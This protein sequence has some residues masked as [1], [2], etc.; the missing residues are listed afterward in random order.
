MRTDRTSSGIASLRAAL[1]L[2]SALA[3]PGIALAQ[4]TAPAVSAK[5]VA[6]M[7]N[8]SGQIDEIVVTAQKRSESLQD[9]PISIQALGTKKLDELQVNNF[10]D[11][12]KY[13]PSVSFQ[14]VGPGFAQVFFRGVSSGENGNHSGPLPTVGIYLDEQPITTI[15]GALDIHVYDIA[16]V[17]ALAGPQGTLYGASSEA[18]TIRI[19]TNKP[20]PTKFSAS[21]DL[22]GTKVDGGGFGGK[23]EGYV[24]VPLSDHVAVRAVGWYQHDG[25]YI[26]NVRGTR[27]YPIKKYDEDGNLVDLPGDDITIDN[28][29]RAK[30]NYNDVDTY[31]GRAQLGIDLDDSW[32]ITP[33]IMA[34]EQKSRG[35]FAFDP[36]VGDLKVTHFFPEGAKD[37]WFQAALTITGKIADFDITYAGA[38]L[39][40]AVDSQSDYTDYS[41][42]YDQCCGYATY[43]RDN[44]GNQIAP[45]QHING[46]DRFT[47][48]SQEF[49]IASPSDKRFRVI[50]GAFYQRQSHN[51]EQ[52]YVIDNLSDLDQVTGTVDDYWL[53]KQQ[54]IDRDYAV[55]GQAD[56]DLTDHLTITAGGRYYKFDNT[57]IG[58]FGYG[59]TGGNE[60]S[61]GTG[62]RG[63]FGPTIVKGSP[64]TNL[65]VVNA[66][67]S[68][69]PKRSKDDGFIHKLSAS[70]KIDGNHLIY[71][72]WSRGFRPGGI[73]RRGTLPPYS[74]DF[75]TNY[76]I[77]TKN[78][79]FDRHVTLNLTVFQ[80]DWKNFQLSA[81]GVNGLTVIQN[82]GN[83]RIRGAEGDLRYQSDGGFSL[84]GSATYTD[85]KL[86]T[87]YCNAAL[88]A[89]ADCTL[90]AGNS[91]IAPKG[92]HLPVT[93]RFKANLIARYAFPLAGVDGHVQAAATYQTS[94]QSDLRTIERAITGK[95]NAYANVDLSEGGEKNQISFEFYIKNVFDKRGDI[96]RLAECI[97]SVC[98]A[99][100]YRVVTQPRTFGIRFGQKF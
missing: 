90:P 4:A 60:F 64:C 12:V 66:D 73:N 37:R 88:G 56:F 86:R 54:R 70:Y 85:S 16:R 14:S 13:L 46:R 75:L 72:T 89:N 100:T 27:T 78:T 96:Q 45:S 97:E 44:A 1:W 28:S 48:L 20:D 47:K 32:T 74:A 5:S 93:P 69:S 8:D 6:T 62:Q 83:A 7:T 92:Q 51:I 30:N 49:R 57:L 11:Y 36:L 82:A 2:T 24:N 38:Y 25:G 19:I 58:F 68:I 31:G 52:N 26:D 77:G 98:G 22:E 99:E 71:A 9:V 61:S 81:L 34:Q 29:S 40:R 95:Q 3:L 67:G 53:T 84:A 87:N 42:F 94:A 65:G 59:P 91:I 17:E 76:E 33:S 23:V 50:A 43:I 63:C 79:F 39:K 80:E 35:T 21:Y 15:Q 55:F 41:F 10:N 18:G